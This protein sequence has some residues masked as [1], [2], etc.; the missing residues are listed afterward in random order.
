EAEALLGSPLPSLPLPDVEAGRPVY[1]VQF[2][3]P[4]RHLLQRQPL[5]LS[6]AIGAALPGA[7]R[8][9]GGGKEAIEYE[10][11]LERMM[12]SVRVADRRGGLGD[13]CRHPR[14]RRPEG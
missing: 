12:R 6:R 3:P 13:L 5:S 9:N 10:V 2:H 1:H 8:I 14:Q 7:P 4:P 11:T